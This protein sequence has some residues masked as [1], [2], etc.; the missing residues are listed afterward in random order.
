MSV[1]L[2]NRLGHKKA[3]TIECINTA[4]KLSKST[5]RRRVVG[6][7]RK[8]TKKYLKREI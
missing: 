5:L 8:L 2:I 7:A 4:A 6:G 3:Q 1:T